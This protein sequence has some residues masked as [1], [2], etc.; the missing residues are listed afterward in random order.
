[1]EIKKVYK[2]AKHSYNIVDFNVDGSFEARDLLKVN[3]SEWK[4]PQ[5]TCLTLANPFIIKKTGNNIG[6][7]S[8]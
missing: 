7:K 4:M 2:R 3:F 1:M 6:K 8:I 5:N